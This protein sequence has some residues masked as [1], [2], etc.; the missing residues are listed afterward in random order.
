MVGGIFPSFLNKIPP[1]DASIFGLCRLG[2]QLSF[3][4]IKLY[5]TI[6]ALAIL[7]V[8]CDDNDPQ[9]VKQ[10][11]ILPLRMEQDDYQR[12]LL[13]DDE[14][15]LSKVKSLSFMPGEVVL[16]STTEYL[17]GPEALIEKVLTDTGFRLEYIYESGRI[18][19]TDQ[20]INDV[21]TQYHT[22]S[23]D[24]KDRL[25]EFVTWQDVPELGGLVP[26]AKEIYLYDSRD[27]LTNQFLYFYDSAI[28]GHQLLTAFEFSDYDDYPEAESLFNGYAYH[29]TAV[30]RRNN[31]GRMVTKNRFGNTV[32][33][34]QYSYAYNPR[35]YVTRK[36][37][38]SVFSYNGSG[39]SYD[40]YYYYEER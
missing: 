26:V 37:T 9:P 20:Y 2:C 6:F 18:V 29:P 35:G 12:E 27:N 21:F 19:R 32:L 34:D 22:F 28:K 30:F 40:T 33:I 10:T 36:T 39:G 17:Y 14:N 38:T 23:Y 4:Q 25:R 5:P 31:P 8:S 1:L 11:V 13:F 16:E 3:M 24:E 15:R 7:F